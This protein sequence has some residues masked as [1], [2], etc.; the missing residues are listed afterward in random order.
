MTNITKGVSVLEITD[1][2]CIEEISATE[3]NVHT[4]NGI[5]DKYKH[6]RQLSKAP[7]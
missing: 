2:D 6:L 4:I 3:Y 7:T 1:S 5:A